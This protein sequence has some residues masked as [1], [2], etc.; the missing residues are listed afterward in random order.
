MSRGVL[1]LFVVLAL[2]ACTGERI[3]NPDSEGG[4]APKAASDEP[5]GD[6]DSQSDTA[7]SR[8]SSTQITDQAGGTTMS[9]E[10]MEAVSPREATKKVMRLPEVRAFTRYVERETSGEVR[11][12]GLIDGE[13]DVEGSRYLIVRVYE[14]HDSRIVTWHRFL[15]GVA[16]GEVLVEDP[17]TGDTLALARWREQQAVED[18]QG[19][20]PQETT[21]GRTDVP[22]FVAYF[23]Q[24]DPEASELSE[25]IFDNR[26]RIVYL[27]IQIPE[28][29]F[30]GAV[31]D[32][33]EGE[34]GPD[35]GFTLLETCAVD[36]APNE[37]PAID[38]CSGWHYVVQ[39]TTE[40]ADYTFFLYRGTY[41]I[42]GNFAVVSADGP[43]QGLMTAILK[44]LDIDDVYGS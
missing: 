15:V 17:A 12:G 25:F 41:R 8:A 5:T 11:V 33:R 19:T 42:S 43:H 3:G 24:L 37:E 18:L 14:D 31:E 38:K 7:S 30:Q 16:D 35:G 27:D 39:N 29:E 21:T 23:G 34:S 9:E 4:K 10:G 13:T 44:P 6:S 1:L 26:G 32:Y 28:G 36:L 22:R 40:A 2:E 20:T